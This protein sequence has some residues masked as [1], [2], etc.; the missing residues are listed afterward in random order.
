MDFTHL[1]RSGNLQAHEACSVVLT[2]APR[3]VILIQ[4]DLGRDLVTGPQEQG[5]KITNF[6]PCRNQSGFPF[7]QYRLLPPHLTHQMRIRHL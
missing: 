7:H 2:F 5:Y 4:G 1:G 3:S 6:G